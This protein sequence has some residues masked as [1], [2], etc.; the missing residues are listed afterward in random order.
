VGDA[1]TDGIAGFFE[2]GIDE[3]LRKRGI[4]S[5]RTAVGSAYGKMAGCLG[6]SGL[7]LCIM[8]AF[9]LKVLE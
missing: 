5:S 4:D 6:G 7:A 9:S 1:I 3:W 8:A 2:G